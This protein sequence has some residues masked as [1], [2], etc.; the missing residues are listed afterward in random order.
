MIMDGSFSGMIVGCTVH[1]GRIAGH[2]YRETFWRPVSRIYSVCVLGVLERVFFRK[3]V[4]KT[5]LG[6]KPSYPI[7][8]LTAIA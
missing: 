8:E 2:I 4:V 1:R 5:R 6:L 7:M 3:I